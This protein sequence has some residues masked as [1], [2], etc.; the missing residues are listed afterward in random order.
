MGTL[1]QSEWC[2]EDGILMYDDGLITDM[3]CVD[4]TDA[5]AF[6]LTYTAHK[7]LRELIEETPILRQRV[8]ELEAQIE[9]MSK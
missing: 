2:V 8:K 9:E 4:G 6:P 5:P 7:A 1:P 3:I